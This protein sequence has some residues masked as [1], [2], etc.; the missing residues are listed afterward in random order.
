MFPARQKLEISD[1]FVASPVVVANNFAAE[2]MSE[3]DS[4]GRVQ[5]EHV[6]RVKHL[7]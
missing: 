3:S 7:A 1:D 4:P 2:T 5:H 6:S